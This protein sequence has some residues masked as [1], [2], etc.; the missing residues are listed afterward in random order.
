M[1]IKE[2][3]SGLETKKVLIV[4]P[5]EENFFAAKE[6]LEGVGLRVD[7]ASDSKKAIE[8]IQGDQFS[9]NGDWYQFVF[10]DYKLET[11]EGAEITKKALENSVRP[12]IITEKDSPL[13]NYENNTSEILI[14]PYGKILQGKKNDPMIWER[15]LQM[16]LD[17][18]LNRLNQRY[19]NSVSLSHQFSARNSSHFLERTLDR[20]KDISSP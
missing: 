8:M 6:Y 5:S 17:Y 19:F 16:T 10:S 14:L 20:Y 11:L 18:F 9:N 1:D 2:K 12:V 13:R 3:I 7:Y 4:D 15:T